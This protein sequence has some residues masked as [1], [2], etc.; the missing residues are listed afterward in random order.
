MIVAISSAGFGG[1]AHEVERAARQRVFDAVETRVAADD[2]EFRGQLALAGKV[3]HVVAADVGHDQVEQHHVELIGDECVEGGLSAERLG[4]LI[5][6]QP[7][8]LGLAFQQ[9]GPVVDHEQ[10]G[11]ARS[12]GRRPLHSWP[13]DR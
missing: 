8:D 12:A 10:A 2:D 6:V 1:F 4:D 9:F 11:S 13:I 7:D 3:E 5:A